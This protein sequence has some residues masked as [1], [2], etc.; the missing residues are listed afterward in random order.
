MCILQRFVKVNKI[1]DFWQHARV[2]RRRGKDMV[3]I[4]PS[5]EV[6]LA[7]ISFTLMTSRPSIL[8]S[9]LLKRRVLISRWFMWE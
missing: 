5:G 7:V 3:V 2:T 6:H 8:P 1:C 9:S 4:G